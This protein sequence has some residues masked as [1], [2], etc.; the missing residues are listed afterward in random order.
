MKNKG[1]G[2]AG[3]AIVVFIAIIAL[4]ADVIAPFD[5]SEIAGPSFSKPSAV[6]ILGTNDIGQDIFSELVV[7]ARFSLA[8]GALTT[9]ISIVAA[10]AVGMTAG[11]CG[12]FVD[13]VLMKITAFIISIPYIP[14]ILVISSLINGSIWTIALVM[15]LTAWPE[16]ARVIR[17]Q[18]LKIKTD[19]YIT[20]II[21]MGAGSRYII[22]K[23]ITRELL[24]LIV[25][26]IASR[27][28]SAILAE[29]SLSFLGFA[30]AIVKSWGKIL[31]QAQSRNA[32]LTGAWVWWAIP[33]GLMITLLTFG[34]TMIS[35]SIEGKTNP[36]SE[37]S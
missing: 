8:V 2:I 35:Y 24:P 34:I 3:I 15:G 1:L 19:D 29:S 16:M 23:H 22:A 17:A 7:G 5:P 36:G 26:R 14:L 10:L 28:R 31:S 33:P 37:K 18:I 6:H 12:G 25:Y 13:S 20:G 21:A 30:P 9:L 32:F 27:F 11:W 4:F